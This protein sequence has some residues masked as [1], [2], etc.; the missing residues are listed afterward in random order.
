MGKNEHIQWKTKQSIL[1][2][3]CISLSLL[4]ISQLSCPPPYCTPTRSPYPHITIESPARALHHMGGS[5][6][7][8]SGYV[9]PSRSGAPIASVTVNSEAAT[10]TPCGSMGGVTFEHTVDLVYGLNIIE[11]TATSSAL[12]TDIAYTSVLYAPSYLDNPGQTLAPATAII[13]GE[14]TFETLGQTAEEHITEEGIGQQLLPHLQLWVDIGSGEFPGVDYGHY[15]GGMETADDYSH[16]GIWV[17]F[18]VRGTPARLTFELFKPQIEVSVDLDVTF[19]AGCLLDEASVFGQMI[20]GVDR[21]WVS[22]DVDF[23]YEDDQLKAD[24]LNLQGDVVD[25]RINTNE[26]HFFPPLGALET[27]GLDGVIMDVLE[28]KMEAVVEPAIRDALDEMLSPG[29][30][31]HEEIQAEINDFLA[32]VPVEWDFPAGPFDTTVGIADLYKTPNGLLVEVSL[33]LDY[34][35]S[36]EIP[37]NPGVLK[38]DDIFYGGEMD[39]EVHFDLKVPLNTLNTVVHAF[40]EN[41]GLDYEVEGGS[42]DPITLVKVRPQTPP[43]IW[44]E[45]PLSDYYKIGIG[46]LL[47]SITLEVASFS[48]TFD[49]AISGWALTM[50]EAEPVPGRDAIRLLVDRPPEQALVY[51]VLLSA[52]EM[53]AL[54]PVLSY[55]IQA[56]DPL[57]I[58]D[59]A[60]NQT[61]QAIEALEFFLPPNTDIPWSAEGLSVS[62]DTN[63]YVVSVKHECPGPTYWVLHGIHEDDMADRVSQLTSLNYRPIWADGF[64]LR[65]RRD[66]DHGDTYY[67]M[68]WVLDDQGEPFVFLYDLSEAV[69][70]LQILL[71]GLDD[72]RPVHLDS[73]FLVPAEEIRYLAIFEEDDGIP[74]TYECNQLDHQFESTYNQ[75]VSDGWRPKNISITKE[76]LQW[77]NRFTSLFERVYSDTFDADWMMEPSAFVAEMVTP[78]RY[79]THVDG[80]ALKG[81]SPELFHLYFSGVWDSAGPGYEAWVFDWNLTWDFLDMNLE[82]WDAKCYEPVMLSGYQTTFAGDHPS[83]DGYCAFVAR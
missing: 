36:S 80:A 33:G 62:K 79:L 78:G 61:E 51:D 31:A 20:V 64:A 56:V 1:F 5:V 19:E 58:L 82:R 40:W 81:P 34:A 6:I 37:P 76:Y 55:I 16:Y 3:F 65:S 12:E 8:V 59:G 38:F 24:V 66:L 25:F 71:L 11:V 83:N 54:D 10:T 35:T 42:G 60:L 52:D 4:F 29:G 44:S 30:T 50:L 77:N 72:M 21:A 7:T 53:A 46:D 39:P 14:E 26:M 47:V 27:A 45:N 75:L 17:D 22:A 49:V 32:E 41:G 43:V 23:Y 69:L 15:S 67:N 57:A 68:I 18:T 28:S 2:L 13:V 70:D 74:T 63:Q 9:N 73:Y 48:F